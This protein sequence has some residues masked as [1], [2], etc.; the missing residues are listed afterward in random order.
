MVGAVVAVRVTVIPEILRV[1]VVVVA[2]RS[3]V[4][5][6]AKPAGAIGVHVMVKATIT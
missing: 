5:T 4:T 1:R 3:I 6:I 2:V